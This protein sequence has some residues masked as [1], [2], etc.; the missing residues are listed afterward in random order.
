MAFEGRTKTIESG[1][2]Q[3]SLEAGVSEIPGEGGLEGIAYSLDSSSLEDTEERSAYGGKE[4]SVFVGVDV[5]DGDS[6][7]LQLCDLSRGFALDVV[8]ADVSAEQM[9]DEV[10]Q[11]SSEGL[12]IGTE[13]RG[14]GLGW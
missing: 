8:F 7:L 9:V 11:G 4:V 2:L 10:E 3:A 13:E 5:C 12:S 6:G 1:D 14:Y